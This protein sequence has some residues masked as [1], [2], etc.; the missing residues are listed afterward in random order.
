MDRNEAELR[1][2]IAELHL[3]PEQAVMSDPAQAA[4]VVDR[5]K[6]AFVKDSDPRWW[7]ACLSKPASV[8]DY[9]GGDAYQHLL[10]FVPP[11]ET[12]CW[13][14]V[15]NDED[16]PWHVLDVATDAV[17]TIIAECGPFEYYLVGQ[18]FNWLIAETHHNQLVVAG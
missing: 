11:G 5:A 2:A 16:G 14:I 18:K 4:Y 6:Q 10:E 15:E 12:R 17:P 8:I 9:P 3:S 1:R 7:W 13:F